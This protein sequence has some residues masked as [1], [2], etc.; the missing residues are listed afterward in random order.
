MSEQIN[1]ISIFVEMSKSYI[2]I[3]LADFPRSL[4]GK[5][6]EERFRSLEKYL[7][8]HQ[9]P[10]EN[11]GETMKIPIHDEFEARQIGA[12]FRLKSL[13]GIFDG[14]PLI[15]NL[16]KKKTLGQPRVKKQNPEDPN[17]VTSLHKLKEINRKQKTEDGILLSLLMKRKIVTKEELKK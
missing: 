14:K 16:E 11:N 2:Y 3:S 15:I 17:E 12:H 9:I 6:P 5:S 8:R 7:E 4:L 13:N 10:F 1:N